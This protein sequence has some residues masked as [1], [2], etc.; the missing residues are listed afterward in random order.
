MS[1]GVPAARRYGARLRAAPIAGFFTLLLLLVPSSGA[2]GQGSFGSSSLNRAAD[3][4]GPIPE[5]RRLALLVGHDSYAD[6]GLAPLQFAAKDAADLAA[7]LSDPARG[8]FDTVIVV[9]ERA[10]TAAGVLSALSRFRD[11]VRPG[12]TVLLYFSGHGLRWLDE[13]NR[14]RVFLATS[15][16]KRDDPLNTAIPVESLQSYLAALPAAR[17]VLMLDSCFTGSGK[18]SEV[19]AAAASRSYVDEDLPLDVKTS[20]REVQLYSTT[21]GRPAMESRSL[22]NGVYTGHFLAALGEHF[23][24]ADMDGDL[25]VTVIEAHDYARDRTLER[26]DGLQ[27]PMAFTKVVGKSEIILSGDPRGRRRVELAFVSAYEG[28]QEGLRMIVDGQERGSF[29]RSLLVEP[30]LRQVEFRSAS[31]KRVDVGRFHFAKRGVY[32][33]RSLRDAITGGRHLLSASYQHL[34]IPGAAYDAESIPQALGL[35]LGYQVR[36][37]SKNP[38]LRRLALSFDLGV[39]L[40]PAQQTNPPELGNSPL[41]GVLDL[42]FGPALRLDFPYLAVTLQPRVAMTALLRQ[43]VQQPFVNWVFGSVG[44]E[45]GVVFRPLNRLAVGMTYSP[46]VFNAALTGTVAVRVMS[47]LSAGVQIGF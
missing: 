46:M 35:R 39:S 2:L 44:G 13:R 38:V 16:T 29:P 40:L 36:S 25:V 26:T 17:R 10:K 6:P 42:G 3:P 15:D 27:V 11:R 21:Y 14:S 5:G 18:I 8:R 4:R 22:E 12:D 9:E 32:S 1:V 24:E 20:D 31:G 7:L 47:R 28:A 41:T 33:V 34:W 37:G 19:Q 23:D 45:V 30:G 43:E